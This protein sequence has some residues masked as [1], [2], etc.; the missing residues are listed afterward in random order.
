M[1]RIGAGGCRRTRALLL[2]A[3]VHAVTALLA[4]ILPAVGKGACCPQRK[5][6]ERE[7]KALPVL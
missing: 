7:E 5:R 4:A 2:F 6:R 1:G 3:S